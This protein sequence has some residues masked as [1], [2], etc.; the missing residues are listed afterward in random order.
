MTAAGEQA[1]AW[2]LAITCPRPSNRAVDDFHVQPE[3][4]ARTAAAFLGPSARLNLTPKTVQF[5]LD[6][7]GDLPDLNQWHERLA[8]ALD[9]LWLSTRT[10]EGK[11]RLPQPARTEI[12]THAAT[13]S[14]RVTRAGQNPP[15]DGDQ[16]T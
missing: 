1:V 8:I 13:D 3:R 2:S 12:R 7:S 9:N 4:A 5:H 16:M 11:Y 6:G 15:T 14:P 10:P